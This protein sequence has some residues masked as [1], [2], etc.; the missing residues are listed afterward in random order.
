MQLFGDSK[1]FCPNVPKKLRDFYLQI[2]SHKNHEDHVLVW[3]L[4]KG[5]N[6]FFCKRWAPFFL[7]WDFD[8][9]FWRFC[10]DFPQIKTFAV[11]LSLPATRL[12]H[13]WQRCRQ[14]CIGVR[15]C[16]YGLQPKHELLFRKGSENRSRRGD[17]NLNLSCNFS[18]LSA[19]L[20]LFVVQRRYLGKE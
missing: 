7:F 12:L 5:L 13:H 18:N 8:Q 4:K 14:V 1:E 19:C 20:C 11:T 10:L 16:T 2:S 6:L 3:L 17:Q 15:A 9:I